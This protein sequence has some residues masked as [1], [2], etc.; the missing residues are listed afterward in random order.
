MLRRV[1]LPKFALL[2]TCL[3]P[4]RARPNHS[5]KPCF[6]GNAEQCHFTQSPRTHSNSQAQFLPSRR[7]VV[8]C[9]AVLADFFTHSTLP[10]RMWWGPDPRSANTPTHL[11]MVGS[12]S[13]VDPAF[14]TC[15]GFLSNKPCIVTQGG[16]NYSFSS[17]CLFP[18]MAT[19]GSDPSL[20]PRVHLLCNKRPVTWLQ[21]AQVS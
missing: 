14:T 21:L 18:F 9:C 11:L 7:K 17:H 4:V 19:S 15:H 1:S 10:A 3:D 13:C 16:V 5:S 20:S 2:S 6:L 8:S 12:S